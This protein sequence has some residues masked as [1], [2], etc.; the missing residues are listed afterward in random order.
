MNC[1]SFRGT[2]R[3]RRRK[4][5][6]SSFK[7]FYL[8]SGCSTVKHSLYY[9]LVTFLLHRESLTCSWSIWWTGTIGIIINRSR[10]YLNVTYIHTAMLVKDI[11][12]SY[13]H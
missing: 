12:P 8:W 5:T 2:R 10:E 1:G 7:P 3:D 6:S 11:Q 4:W 9:V 13:D